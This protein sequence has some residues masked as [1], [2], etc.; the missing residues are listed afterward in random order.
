MAYDGGRTE[1]PGRESCAGDKPRGAIPSPPRGIPRQ[2]PSNLL[3]RRR[4]SRIRKKAQIKFIFT[5]V[6]VIPSERRRNGTNDTGIPPARRWC[7]PDRGVW[8]GKGRHGRC[9]GR[10]GPRIFC[11][12][13]VNLSARR[14]WVSPHRVGCAAGARLSHKSSP[15]DV[16]Q[17][18]SSGRNFLGR[19]GV[20]TRTN[21]RQQLACEKRDRRVAGK[22]PI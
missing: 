18:G 7:T 17:S 21:T 6:A 3:S 1:I 15:R 19:K 11:A 13:P 14:N 16:P 8:R 12:D 20:G 9:G 2:H 10:C 5:G 4:R 22:A